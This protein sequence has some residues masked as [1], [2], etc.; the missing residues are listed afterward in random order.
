MY[1][2]K[3][4]FNHELFQG[5]NKKRNY[6]EGWYF[7]IINKNKTNAFAIIPG[8][9]YDNN[10]KDNHAFIQVLDINNNVYYFRFDIS[11]F[12]FN[13]KKFEVKIGDNYFSKNKVHLNLRNN[14]IT[15]SGSLRFN[16]IVELPK[17]FYIPGIMGPFSYIPFMECYHAIVNIHHEIDG[18]IK[19]NEEKIFFNDG[20]G[21]IEKDWGKSFPKSWIWLQSN[22]FK[23]NDVSVMFS[24]ADI[25]FMGRTFKGFIS[26]IRIKEI[27]YIF[28]TYTNAKLQIYNINTETPKIL[29]IDK[30]Y[31]LE[32][33]INKI[34]GGIL[35]APDKGLMKRNIKESLNAIIQV[36]LSDHT[37]FTIFEGSGTNTGLEIVK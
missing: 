14:K 9:S 22:H 25:P 2:I 31:K 15:I 33:D 11:D 8:V 16:N 13:K 32:I 30:K 7:K 20:Y 27:V 26:F 23:N 35:K 36:K 18:F 37:G 24:V 12:K 34:S 1:C 10:K 17:S 19:V 6:F 4:M 28:A 21:Y 3:K 5:K 29:L